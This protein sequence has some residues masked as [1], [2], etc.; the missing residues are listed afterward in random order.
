M[1]HNAFLHALCD[2]YGRYTGYLTGRYTE[3][4]TDIPAAVPVGVRKMA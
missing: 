2:Q 1:N 4:C 3:L